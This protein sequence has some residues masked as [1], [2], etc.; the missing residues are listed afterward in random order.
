MFWILI[1][2]GLRAPIKVRVGDRI[3]F[4]LMMR[5]RVRV[6]VRFWVRALLGLGLELLL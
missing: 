1:R 4:E 5:I 3:R 2:V 6:R